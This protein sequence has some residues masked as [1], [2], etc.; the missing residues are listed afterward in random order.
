M[1]RKISM[2]QTTHAL[3]LRRTVE[4]VGVFR[5]QQPQREGDAFAVQSRN[6]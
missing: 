5:V 3:G 6:M 2:Q 4:G 1:T